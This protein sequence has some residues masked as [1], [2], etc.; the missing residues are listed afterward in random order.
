MSRRR[1]D[2]PSVI[3]KGARRAG[4][5]RSRAQQP[6]SIIIAK[7]LGWSGVSPLRGRH[8][9]SPRVGSAP[10]ARWLAL[11]TA[12]LGM[13]AAFLVITASVAILAPMARALHTSGTE[14]VW[15]AS[16]Y[17][18]AV[19]CLVLTAAT[20]GDVIGR[21]RV[22]ATGVFVLGLG[23]LLVA[24][25]ADTGVVLLGQAV[26]GIGGAMVLPNS[27]AIVANL[28]A[29]PRERTAAVSAWAAVSGLGLAAGPVVGGVLLLWFSWRSVFFLTIA[30][31][32]FVLV[33]VPFFIPDSRS[34]GRRLDPLGLVLGVL[35]IGALSYGVIQG[36]NDGYATTAILA[37]FCVAAV[38]A[39]AFVAAERNSAAPMLHLPLFANPSFSAANAAAFVAQFSFVGIAFVELLYFEQVKRYSVLELG[40]RLLALT[41]TYVITSAVASHVV[42]WLGFKVVITGGLVLLGAGGFLLLAQGPSTSPTAI[43][44]VL[45]LCAVGVGFVLPPATAVAVISVEDHQGGMASGAVN[46]SRQV[47]SALGAAIL[48]TVLT[49]GLGANLPGALTARGVPAPTARKIAAA[50]TGGG[51]R[52]S[53]PVSLRGTVDS[54]VGSAFATA[55]Q[56]AV[57]IPGMLALVMAIITAAFLRARPVNPADPAASLAELVAEAGTDP[58][59]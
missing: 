17:S 4:E 6:G 34:P 55:M 16:I 24:L 49:S 45:A 13:M 1:V 7:T 5:S 44:L 59:P 33:L 12:C 40:I 20:V 56:H 43:S 41:G 58:A 36:G 3:R 15:V 10:L 14:E 47:G 29:D 21:R 11:V 46:M 23:S 8:E 57:L 39:A 25:A 32:A 26:M 30:L 53:V 19:S 35:A 2:A 48:G 31:A 18:L 37:T 51:S 52:G 50:A 22:F 9:V 54:A 42:R 28:F 38:S 27:L